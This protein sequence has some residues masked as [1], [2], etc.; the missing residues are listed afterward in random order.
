MASDCSG[1]SFDMSCDN[2]GNMMDSG[3]YLNGAGLPYSGN[4]G[5]NQQGLSSANCN[6]L[7]TQHFQENNCDPIAELNNLE[8]MDYTGLY[9][10][11][12]RIKYKQT[13]F[14]GGG[15]IQRAEGGY[16]KR[17]R[18]CLCNDPSDPYG[19]GKYH[20]GYKRTNRAC[21][22]CCA[23]IGST[24]FSYGGGDVLPIYTQR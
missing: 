10:T 12:S 4:G 20:C 3:E 17:V 6:S 15:G 8:N 18:E 16:G 5:N 1:T 11:A 24:V 21:R 23:N 14:G 13:P 9:N 2:T 7:A 19:E 22:K